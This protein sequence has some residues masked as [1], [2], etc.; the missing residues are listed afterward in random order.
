[1]PMFLFHDD[2]LIFKVFKKGK[3]VLTFTTGQFHRL[4]LPLK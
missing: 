1:M 2:L 3:T 4:K